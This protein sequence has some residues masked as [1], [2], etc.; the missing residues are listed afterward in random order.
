M[1]AAPAPCP[2]SDYETENE[3][4]IDFPVF[5]QIFAALPFYGLRPTKR[6]TCRFPILLGGRNNEAGHAGP[7]AQCI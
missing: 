1:R 3:N 4:S 2:S 5:I 7:A 6:K